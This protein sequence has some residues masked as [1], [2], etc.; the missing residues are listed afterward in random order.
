MAIG[1][2]SVLRI[3]QLRGVIDYFYNE[4]IGCNENALLDG[5]EYIAWTE[6]Q[7]IDEI[8]SDILNCKGF[9]NMENT[10]EMVEAK[11]F[12]FLGKENLYTLVQAVCSYRH[13]T[14]GK[15]EWEE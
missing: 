4:Y 5:E 9:L 8:V 15:W 6:Q 10:C 7:L 14:E 2:L 1:E 11:H 3:K 12:R 13:Q